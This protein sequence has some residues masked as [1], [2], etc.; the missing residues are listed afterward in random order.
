MQLDDYVR[1]S[2]VL[3][4][5]YYHEKKNTGQKKAPKQKLR[6]LKK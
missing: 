1:K 5:C 2:A 4:Y 6:G 3:F